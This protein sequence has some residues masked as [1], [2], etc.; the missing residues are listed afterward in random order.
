MA[1]G[2]NVRERVA[3][4]LASDSA[5]KEGYEAYIAAGYD[6]SKLVLVDGDRPTRFHV[7]RLT[8]DA[9]KRVDDLDGSERLEFLLRASLE[10]IENYQVRRSADGPAADLAPPEFD[11]HKEF[12]PLLKVQWLRD[13]MLPTTV[14]MAVGA[15][16]R[17]LS[18]Y[19]LP[20]PDA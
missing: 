15:A 17:H 5:I 18:E 10:K 19:D 1:I 7:R 6:E 12:G 4:I 2:H 14:M 20:F 9:R 16:A 3:I 13:A 8:Y 11:D